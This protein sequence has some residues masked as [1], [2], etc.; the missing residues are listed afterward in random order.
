MAVP[1][2]LPFKDI[3][4]SKHYHLYGK[5]ILKNNEE[6]TDITKKKVLWSLLFSIVTIYGNGIYLSS[7]KCYHIW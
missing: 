1:E 2:A 5:A 3:P 6:N 7:M 4:M